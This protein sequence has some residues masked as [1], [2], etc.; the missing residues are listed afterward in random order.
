MVANGMRDMGYKWML[1]DDCWSDTERDSNGELQPSPKLFPSGMKALADYIHANGM[2]LGLY[3]CVGTETC[4]KGRP[5]S[6]GH[7][8]IDANTFAK[9]GADMVKADY[10]HKPTNE[11]GRDLYTQFSQALNATGRPMLFATCQWG[12]DNV[13]EWG[14]DIAQ[15]YRIQMDHIPFWSWPPQA[16]GVGYGQGTKQIIDFMADL[17]PSKYNRPHAWM[18]PDFLETLFEPLGIDWFPMNFTNSRTEMT[19]WSL[20]SSPLLVATDPAALSDEKKAILMNPEVIAINQDTLW[21]AGERIRNDNTTTG[22][23]VWTRPLLNGDLAVVLYNSGNANGVS[24]AVS[25]EELGWASSDSVLV[26][27][28]WARLDLGLFTQSVE[29]T[30]DAHDVKLLRMIRS[31]AVSGK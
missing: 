6:Y 12:E 2:Y 20:W 24:V 14:G 21:S 25:W 13:V 30:L 29:A 28:L 9:W 10:C 11:T 3:S 18:D 8:V 7:Y 19:F 16:A 23:Q 31:G 1:L 4:K 22:G 27:D 15:M 26:R 5:G 17:H